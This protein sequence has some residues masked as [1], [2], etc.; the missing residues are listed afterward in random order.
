MP[1]WIEIQGEG[2]RRDGVKLC[3]GRTGRGVMLFAR[4]S[5]VTHVVGEHV[6]ALLT[7]L[8]NLAGKSTDE[9]PSP[10]AGH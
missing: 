5:D 9:P 8:S 7:Q 2:I 4:P 3:L 6:E 1:N 10:P